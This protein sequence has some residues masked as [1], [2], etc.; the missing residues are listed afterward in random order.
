M[1]KKLFGLILA[2][3]MVLSLNVAVFGVDGG[4]WPNVTS[5]PI[6]ISCNCQDLNQ[7]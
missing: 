4:G 1:K 7:Y 5:M 6:C 3:A 2:A